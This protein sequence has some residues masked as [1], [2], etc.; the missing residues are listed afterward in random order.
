MF[1]KFSDLNEGALSSTPYFSKSLHFNDLH[2]TE[3]MVTIA[4]KER[5]KKAA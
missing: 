3:Y 2:D 5:M 4:M 1:R